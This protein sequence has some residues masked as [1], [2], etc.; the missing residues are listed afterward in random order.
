[1]AEPALPPTES[2]RPKVGQV[3]LF[4]IAN[5]LPERGS[6]HKPGLVAKK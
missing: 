2:L 6:Q 1:M 5:R 4:R 3:R